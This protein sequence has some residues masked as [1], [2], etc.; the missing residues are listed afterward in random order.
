MLH[1][2]PRL[3]QLRLRLLQRVLLHEHRLRQNVQSIGIRSQTL[4][5]HLLRVHVLLC[6]LRLLHAVDEAA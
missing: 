4:P 6:Q 3:D 2:R 1:L 5:Q